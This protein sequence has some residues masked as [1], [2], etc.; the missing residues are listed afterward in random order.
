MAAEDESVL[1]VLVDWGK[2][3]EVL[4]VKSRNLEA[5]LKSKL[6]SS[7]SK[8]PQLLPYDGTSPRVKG[9]Y[10]LQK[11]SERWQCYIDCEKEGIEDGDKL[12]I[13]ECDC[14]VR[15]LQN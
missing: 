7:S 2:S 3:K 13:V 9:T 12:S 14:E 4:K 11:W 1:E 8:G 5:Y 15:S 10:I 6:P